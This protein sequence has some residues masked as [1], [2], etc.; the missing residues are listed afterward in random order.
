MGLGASPWRR[1]SGFTQQLSRAG[2]SFPNKQDKAN[3]P[4][5]HNMHQHLGGHYLLKTFL[6]LDQMGLSSLVY[7]TVSLHVR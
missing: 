7:L 5:S 1:D 4:K 2:G 3:C 6:S